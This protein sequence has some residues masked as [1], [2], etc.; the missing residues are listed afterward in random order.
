[1]EKNKF[2]KVKGLII[3]ISFLCFRTEAQDRDTYAEKWNFVLFQHGTFK[4]EVGGVMSKDFY[5]MRQPTF[6]INYISDMF[7]INAAAVTSLVYGTHELISGKLY[8]ASNSPLLEFGWGFNLNTNNPIAFA[9]STDMI[10]GI[11]FNMGGINVSADRLDWQS[12]KAALRFS[13]AFIGPTIGANIQIDD[14]VNIQNVLELSLAGN[15]TS[16]GTR[17]EAYSNI[18]VFLTNRIAFSIIPTFQKYN[19]QVNDNGLETR[20]KTF[21]KFIQYGLTFKFN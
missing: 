2:L 5:K 10:F 7:Y 15:A 21:S 6:E 4:Q 12:T 11:G 14:R 3:L 16:K 18:N 20:T 8:K 9:P 1:M 17:I 13:G 19:L